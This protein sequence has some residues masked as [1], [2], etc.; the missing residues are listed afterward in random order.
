MLIQTTKGEVDDSVLEKR[1]HVTPEGVKVTEYYYDGE[2]VHRSASTEL[3][4]APA[5]GA[6]TA[7]FG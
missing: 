5:M 7:S 4:P 3:T 2:L 1:E 6:A